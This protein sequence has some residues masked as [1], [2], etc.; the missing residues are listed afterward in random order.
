MMPH[1]Y[2]LT[3][4]ALAFVGS[5]SAQ[6]GSTSFDLLAEN[7]AAHAAH[8][9][10]QHF[11]FDGGE[12]DTTVRFMSHALGGGAK[13]VKNAPYTAEAVSETTQVL[14]DGN[15][16]VRRSTTSLARDGEGRTRQE[17]RGE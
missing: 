2:S 17:T 14:G 3:L 9:Y 10:A 5:A 4:L 13:P 8:E 7:T 16:I 12:A 15:R 6:T 11:A 1:A